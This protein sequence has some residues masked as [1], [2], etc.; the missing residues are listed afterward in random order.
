MAWMLSAEEECGMRDF[1]TMQGAEEECGMQISA[2]L[3]AET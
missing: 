3:R 2:Q 1:E